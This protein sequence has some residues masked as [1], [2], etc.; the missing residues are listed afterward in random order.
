MPNI[1]GGRGQTIYVDGI[2]GGDGGG[3]GNFSGAVNMDAIEEVNVQMS[4]YTAEHGMKGGAQVNSSPSTAVGVPRHRL[5]G[6]CATSRSTRRTSSTTRRILPVYRYS[7]QGGTIGGLFQR[8]KI[9]S[10]GNKPFFFYSLDDTQL[11]DANILRRYT[12]PT[13]AE[14][15]GDFSNTR[16][17]NGTLIV[18]RDSLTGQPFPDNKIPLDR[19]DAR[20]MALIN[21][22]PLPNANG[23]G[24][25]FVYQSRASASAPP[26]FD[27]VDYRPTSSQTIS[28]I[29]ELGTP[30][31]S[32]ITW[33]AR[34]RAGVLR[35]RAI[36]RWT[37]RSWTTPESS[38][39]RRF[40]KSTP[41]SS[42]ALNW[43]RPRMKRRWQ[44]SSERPIRRSRTCRSS[45]PS[46]IPWA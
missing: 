22:I 7:T 18:V 3:G 25:N 30:R 38:T 15:Q 28:K 32:G 12:V 13:A 41:A 14:R 21:F 34:R 23:S 24:Y 17:T 46:G 2:N 31:A 26:A 43:A 6:I 20:S 1:Q 19:M 35:Q 45:R 27:P 44:G 36:S 40:S 9:N 5:L 37:R 11:K 42:T 16:Q 33:R 29:F 4:A 39:R 8:F 10:D